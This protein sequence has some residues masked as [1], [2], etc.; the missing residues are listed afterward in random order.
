MDSLNRQKSAF[1]S[2]SPAEKRSYFL[3]NI[4]RRRVLPKQNSSSS[5]LN[6]A[7]IADSSK[8]LKGRKSDGVLNIC[9]KASD[10]SEE[11]RDF[12]KLLDYA[13]REIADI[14]QDLTEMTETVSKLNTPR[15]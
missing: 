12:F 7:F 2:M 6:R 8:S 1:F 9:D 10:K 4:I 13:L 11:T 3:K 15:L 5:I 14:K